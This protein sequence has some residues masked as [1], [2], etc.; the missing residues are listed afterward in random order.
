MFKN[1][2]IK[3]CLMAIELP[4]IERKKIKVPI[5]LYFSFF[6]L[7]ITILICVY[8]QL[9]TL[10]IIFVFIGLLNLFFILLYILMTG[11]IEEGRIIISENTIIINSKEKYEFNIKDLQLG[12]EINRFKNLSYTQNYWWNRSREYD[13][14]LKNY[15]GFKYKNKYYQY[16]FCLNNKIKYNELIEILKN[17]ELKFNRKVTFNNIK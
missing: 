16:E 3:D 1:L 2:R 7:L 4:I 11:L 6:V 5:I 12:I 14:G 15:I 13:D 8:Y 17:I 9:K 10:T